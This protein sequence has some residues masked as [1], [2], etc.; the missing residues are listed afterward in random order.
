[1][2]LPT[3]HFDV[4]ILGTGL[5]QSILSA[6]LA[7]AGRSVLHV[8]SNDYYGGDC[9]SLSLGELVDHVERTAESKKA[10]SST[11]WINFPSHVPEAAQEASRSPAAKIPED[12]RKLDRHYSLSLSPSLLPA[13]GE[14]IDVLVRSGVASYATFRLLESTTVY[15][16]SAT[17]ASPSAVSQLRT[18]PCSKE[19][20]FKDRALSLPDKR[21][22]MK[23]LMNVAQ[24]SSVA[25]VVESDAYEEPFLSYLQGKH[26][27]SD[28]VAQTLAY[29]V[30]LCSHPDEPTKEALTRAKQHLS[31]I[32]RFGNSSY[33][34]GQYGG[35][36]ELAQSYCRAAA[37][38]GAIYILGH[39]LSDMK[40]AQGFERAQQG[41]NGDSRAAETNQTSDGPTQSWDFGLKDLPEEGRLTADWV[42]GEP[43]TLTTLIP[44]QYDDDASVNATSQKPSLLTATPNAKSLEAI[45]VLDRPIALQ[46]SPTSTNA[47]ETQGRSEITAAPLPPETALVVFPPASLVPHHGSAVTAL[48]MGEGTFSCPKG[49][50]VYYLSTNIASAA[51]PGAGREVF[52]ATKRA[53]CQLAASSTAESGT[54]ASDWESRHERTDRP[55]EVVPLVECFRCSPTDSAIDLARY[56]RLVPVPS[57]RHQA[58]GAGKITNLSTWLDL[59]TSQAES[60]FWTIEGVEKRQAAEKNVEARRRRRDP[61]EYVGRVGA[62]EKD[63]ADEDE[64][65]VEF[66]QPKRTREEQ[67]EE[68]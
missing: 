31:G 55:E 60:L 62:T 12:L 34:V 46:N 45:I 39:E 51:G 32:G 24:A 63:E 6:A 2:S 15:I 16:P 38:Y 26:G 58:S 41:I 22:I 20:V 30:A 50:Y 37:V 49:Q 43:N 13:S 27:L 56:P 8:D 40:P 48:M 36:G 52:E 65:V 9:A 14:A 11:A 35:A 47:N 7:K 59:A 61:A 54:E 57:A 17:S 21:R 42:V 28:A 19:D 10:S 18:V 23:L 66:F 67:D 68:E 29:G 4:L 3:K 1:M 53:L 64:Q 44:C 33:L 5:A 25:D